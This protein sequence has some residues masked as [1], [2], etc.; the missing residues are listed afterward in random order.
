MNDRLLRNSSRWLALAAV[1]ALVGLQA[2]CSDPSMPS[3]DTG[4]TTDTGNNGMDSTVDSGVSPMDSGVDPDT[5]SMPADT[6]VDSGVIVDT[7]ADVPPPRC[8]AGVDSDGD[9]LDNAAECAAMTD[10]YNPDS[11]MDGVS[12]GT[13]ARYPRACIAT[14]PARQRRP[15]VRCT[16]DTDCMAG[17]VCRGLDPRSRDSDM[18]GVPD[19][20][21]D[22]NFDGTIDSGRGETDPRLA[23]TDG[24]GTP[25][26]MS[27]LAI[28]RPSGLG[29]VVQN[30]IPG[31]P[32]QVGY[33]PSWRN[34]GRVTGTMN[35]GAIVLD[36]VMANVSGIVAAQPSVGA[37]A[38]AES[39]RIEPIITAALGAGTAAVLVGRAIRTHEMND[40]ITSTYRVAR[41]TSA[42]A[43]RDALVMPLTGAAAPASMGV[44]GMSAEFL[45]DI[46]VVRRTT[47]MAMGTTDILVTIAPRTAYEDAAQIT[48]IRAIDLVNSTATAQIDRGL[49]FQCQ[50][51]RAMG[52]P[53]VDFIW[54][55]DTSGSMGPYQERVGRTANAFFTRMQAA[56]INFRVGVLQAGS[57]TTGPNLDTPGFTWISG[58]DATGARQLCDRVT[59]AGLGTCPLAT[60]AMPDTQSPYPFT[61]SQEEPTA[62]AI[63]T[64]RTMSM[65]PATDARR[66]RPAPARFVAFFVTDE[67]GTNDYNRYFINNTD[68]SLVP[69]RPWAGTAGA[70]YSLTAQNNI[71]DYFRRNN[72]LTFGLLPRTATLACSTAPVNELPRCV[73][74]G[75]GGAVI[76]IA[77]ATDA[78]VAV[79]MNRIVDAIAGASSQF[80]LTS[81]PITSTLKVSVRGMNVP[82]SRAN[83]FDY[84][85]ASNAIVFYGTTYRP[86]SGDEVVISYRIWQPCP[87][88]GGACTTDAQCCLPHVCRMGRCLTPCVMTAGTCVDNADCCAPNICVS[89]RC[90]PPTT[91]RPAGDMCMTN[92]DCCSP[93][94]CVSGRCTPPPPCRPVGDMCTTA[95][96]C[97]D[98][99]C[100]GGRCAPPPCRNVG[101]S[102]T[103]AS[104]CCDRSCIGGVCA[105]G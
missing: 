105:P 8:A 18:D 87:S 3:G 34:G 100:V 20:E 24:D 30:G 82:R 40:A 28:C 52:T 29:T 5:G 79:A 56:G 12:D 98:R 49:G 53:E 14:M 1:S 81:T 70:A 86:R 47:G 9:G 54:T 51:F 16:M 33:A 32:V 90:A 37:D 62:A 39:M 21:E 92:A 38:R 103:T 35:R 36:E 95:A 42:S 6:G 63:L 50:T 59:S 97:C 104:D 7:G 71:I 80:R 73:V 61:P 41:A 69:A 77:T 57:V 96:D 23:D 4:V 43:L 66:F 89:G 102:C 99:N 55:V 2:A 83:G 101:Q 19:N 78:E 85:S 46:T 15:V 26:N 10:P 91:C 65:R 64:H 25:D 68:S 74:E 44:V 13:E 31:R 48:S 27:G 76:P 84:D 93:N 60:A 58:A 11:D 72:I 17:E 22:T 75:N 94:T 67:P 45:V 88:T